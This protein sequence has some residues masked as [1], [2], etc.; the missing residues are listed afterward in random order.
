MFIII[1]QENRL[2]A[3]SEDAL[4]RLGASNIYDAVRL[5]EGGEI[6]VHPEKGEIVDGSGVLLLRGSFDTLPSLIG[7]LQGGSFD[8]AERYT[9]EES[10]KGSEMEL[11]SPSAAVV[12]GSPD[13]ESEE[14][15]L[16]DLLLTKEEEE[17]GASS[18]ENVLN[19]PKE[20]T[21]ELSTGE[22]APE[23]GGEELLELL[24][25]EESHPTEEPEKEES[26]QEESP[27]EE[28]ALIPL[29]EEVVEE[30]SV[31]ETPEEKARKLAA[32]KEA[33]WRGLLDSF[34]PDLE[35]NAGKIDLGKEE[36]IDLLRE[37]IEDCEA[38]KK[39]LA[40]D[41]TSRSDRA[42]GTLLDATTLL[43]LEPLPAFFRTFLQSPA[44]ERS[45]MAKA[46]YGLLGKLKKEILSPTPSTGTPNLT[47]PPSEEIVEET[48]IEKPAEEPEELFSQAPST[49][50]TAIPAP[51]PPPP[52]AELNEST[53]A[54]L[55]DIQPVPV[56]FSLK[57]A[58]EELNLPED[59]VL[60]FINDFAGQGHEYLPELIDAYQK[61]DI[62]RLQKTA[63]MLKGA[64]SN[65]RLEA[66]VEN[67][68]ELQFDNDIQRAP[69]RIKLFAG[70]LMSLDKYLEQMNS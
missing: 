45:E 60:E 9:V 10:V 70:Q 47:A 65:L 64:A 21:E 5:Q 38:L 53:E 46:F 15:E 7:P 18:S 35:E 4:H 16:I 43:Q 6:V 61:K 33:A 19:T 48:E 31:V 63:H 1:N 17:A 28:E 39:D 68:Y 27:T 52:S 59:L 34:H 40:S 8:A 32:E 69:K 37:F 23:S 62:D 3:A 36:Y 25:I 30:L 26:L 11:P 54:F 50:E 44:E 57:V 56:E 22:E 41:D 51:P 13:E 42:A 67:L 29:E 20:E 49:E 24:E 66:M 12:T 55:K 14:S 2:I 58:A